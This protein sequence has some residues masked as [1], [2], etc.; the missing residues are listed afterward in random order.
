MPSSRVSSVRLDALWQQAREAVLVLNAERRFIYVNRAWEE[1]TGHLASAV[2]GLVCNPHGPSVPDELDGLGGSFCPP[3]EALAGQ[4]SG[5]PTLIVRASGERLWRRVEFWPFHDE[6]DQLLCLLGLV[7]DADDPTRVPDSE[8]SRPRVALM[9][10]RER[11][12]RRY[13]FENLI[14]RGPSHRR[15]LDQI[16]ASAATSVP[17]LIVGEPGTGKRLV[18][19]IIHQQGPRSGSL[20]LPIDCAALPPEV[21]ERELFEECGE[22]SAHRLRLP[23]GSSLLLSDILELTR[24]LQARLAGVI[25]DRVRLL[26]TTAGDP[27]QALQSGRLRPDLYYALTTLV[28]RL[29][30]LRERLDDLPLLGQHLLERANARGER[31]RLG[32]SPEALDVLA[33]YDWPG[34]LRELERVID[35]AHAQ[36]DGDLVQANDLPAAIRGHLG[37]AYTPPPMPPPVTPLDE[38]LTQLERRLI[39][40]ALLKARQNK[41]RAAELL[42][43]SRPRLYRR[44]KELNI[45]DEPETADAQSGSARKGAAVVAGPRTAPDETPGALPA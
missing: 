21:I 13:G 30:P 36:G 35:A 6:R 3:P 38:L 4:P 19:R 16:T 11:L 39:E 9:E 31:Q 34:N 40:Q 27:E 45:P 24:D 23:E 42:E 10:I 20:L 37:S 14:G 7:R 41:S 2:L 29:S 28:I 1:L 15:L 32:F 26:A 5:A 18:T 22:A 8:A 33:G 12:R 17:V 43:I 25:D 44:I